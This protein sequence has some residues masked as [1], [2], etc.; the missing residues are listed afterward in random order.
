MQSQSQIDQDEQSGSQEMALSSYLRLHPVLSLESTSHQT[1]QLVADLIKDTAIPTKELDIIP[2]SWDD[3]Y[4]RPPNLAIGE[5]PCCLGNRCICVELARWRY[6]NDTDLAFVG[7]EFLLPKQHEAFVANGT[8][9]P[10][11]QMAVFSQ[12]TQ[13]TQPTRP[14]QPTRPTQPTKSTQPAQASAQNFSKTAALIRLCY[15]ELLEELKSL[16][17]TRP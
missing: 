11:S 4:L 5:R 14:S 13:P 7:T 2:K 6:G 16:H 3:S 17:R 1:L 10:K 8:L 12:P 15:G 9:P